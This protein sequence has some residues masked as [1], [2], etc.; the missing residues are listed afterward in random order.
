[1][2]R[3]G[4]ATA[5]AAVAS[6]ASLLGLTTL[7]QTQTWYSRAVW[8][9][10][11]VA[12]A[13]TLMRRVTSR[14]LLVAAVQVT[15]VV[16]VTTWL[17]AGSTTWYGVPTL[18]S[19]RAVGSLFGQ[20]GQTIYSSSAPIPGTL[21]VE[22]TLALLGASVALLV[23]YIAVGRGAPAAAGLPLLTAF[24]AAAANSGSALSPL[25]FLIAAAAWLL[26]LGRQAQVGM[27]RWAS[28]TARPLTPSG[29]T[30]D[31][32]VSRFGSIARRLA[33]VGLVTA[34][35]VPTMMPHL[36]PRYLLDGLA[37]SA[38]GRGNAKV[39]FNSTLDVG[40]SL[41]SGDS[42]VVLTYR[43][44]AAAPAPL[45]V[46]SATTYDG[47]SW[48]R[49]SPTLGSSAR[50]EL[51]GSVPRTERMIVVESYALDPPSLATPQPVIAADL[52]GVSWQVDEST[53]DI[54]VQTKPSTYTTSY[55]EV[56]PTAE[57]LRDGVDGKPGTDPLP[58]S[59][60]F[61]AAL[62]LDPASA[63]VVQGT[64]ARVTAQ[65][66]TR[67]DAAVAIQ[68]WLRTSGGFSY[69]LTLP[70]PS[71]E[72]A[73]PPA[74]GSAGSDGSTVL[75][76]RDPI[77]WFLQSK[78]GY[79]VQFASAMV[80]M[81]R[82]IG[83]PARMA[84]GFLPG[85]QQEGLW[86]VTSA[87]AH[88][89]P[90][91]YFAGSGWVRFEP[92]PQSRTGAAPSWTLPLPQNVPLPTSTARLTDD[93]LERLERDPDAGALETG[94]TTE[95][96]LPVLERIRT[97]LADGAHLLLA[98][99]V[100]VVIGALILPVTAALVRRLRSRRGGPPDVVVEQQWSAFTS[101][102]DDLGVRP[103]PGG[104]LRDWQHQLTRDGYL[105]DPA[106]EALATLVLTVERARYA[107]PGAAIDADLR[108]HTRA[109]LAD[110]SQSRAWQQRVHA[111]L[112]P[113]A[114]RQWWGAVGRRLLVGPRA[115]ARR[116][117]RLRPTSRPRR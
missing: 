40:R 43:T 75:T 90:E 95:L 56:A 5:L 111:W 77:S 39:G 101:Q 107:R 73:Q 97:W 116:L 65:A 114:G 81:A 83:I 2:T 37:R 63:A 64:A 110:V 104:T 58:S 17:Y 28:T 16:F 1:M 31:V 113:S 55:L 88:S 106:R 99:V 12:V 42:S 59:R 72:A 20:F 53:S 84:I 49:P 108:R 109:V 23:D 35:A 93:P 112:A 60:A 10:I 98:I 52:S 50:L 14:A 62:R 91:L 61:A 85:S 25:Y 33:I 87:D 6:L 38:D 68:E 79:C 8:F 115:L 22:V 19:A 21:G 66:G 48:Q 82:A 4:G 54:Y 89:W 94:I 57:M 29:A 78:Q 32:T 41:T 70:E 76:G 71:S 117:A 15:A 26:M 86:R 47:T 11:V 13:G 51:D 102:L 69:S 34:V 103:T 100:L 44:N 18:A 92:T 105:D 67:Y 7:V 36:P 46:L 45:R 9:V 74:A 80:M 30:T 96:D 3:R 27:R 24:L